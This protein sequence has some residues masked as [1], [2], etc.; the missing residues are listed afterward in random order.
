MRESNPNSLALD[1]K[2]VFEELKGYAARG[3]LHNLKEALETRWDLLEEFS[4]LSWFDGNMM[5][6][7]IRRNSLTGSNKTTV[8]Q[9]V[10][11]TA[12]KEGHAN[13]A[14]HLLDRG[15]C[16][17]TPPAVRC[18]M[19]KESWDVLQVYLDHGWNINSSVEG[20]NTLPIIYFA[21]RSIAQV[22]WC[23]EHGADPTIG[24]CK[25]NNDIPSHMGYYGTVEMV[26][27]LKEH[28]VDFTKS[29]AL[30]DA[31]SSYIQ[32]RIEVMAYLL[33]EA[34][35][36]INSKE[37]EYDP[38]LF[39]VWSPYRDSTALH[40][41]ARLKKLG[42]LKFLLERNADRSIKNGFGKTAA[43]LAREA[44]F[45]EAIPLLTD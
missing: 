36:P 21:V 14:R 8:L 19:G 38:D 39:E 15:Y 12:A 44:G 41:A 1:P 10:L 20:G 16:V 30:Q 7:F 42:N 33:D 17:I 5:D 18:A 31:A 25:R 4:D 3:D 22:K 11:N 23:L 40:R 13:I 45:D 6:H 24:N 37:Y 2:A 29:N 26:R 35:V 43:D 32:G 28:G 9:R 27:A 34:K